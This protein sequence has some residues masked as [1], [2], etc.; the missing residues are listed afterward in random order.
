MELR[1]FCWFLILRSTYPTTVP[2]NQPEKQ[3]TMLSFSQFFP[4]LAFRQG[5]G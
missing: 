1:L 5:M 4:V 2:G 3:M